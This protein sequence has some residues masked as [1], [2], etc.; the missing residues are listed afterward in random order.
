MHEPSQRL[1][2]HT[3]PHTAPSHRLSHLIAS[4]LHLVGPTWLG[5]FWAQ[6]A[7]RLT[8]LPG[9]GK[10]LFE[11]HVYS[12]VRA[13]DLIELEAVVM[14][15]LALL[16]HFE[17]STGLST[18]LGEWALDNIA[19]PLQPEAVARWWYGQASRRSSGGQSLGLSVWNYDGPGGWG[20]LVPNHEQPRSWWAKLNGGD[21]DG[22][23]WKWSDHGAVSAR[24][25]SGVGEL[26]L[27]S[28]SGA[29]ESLTVLFDKVEVMSWSR[30]RLLN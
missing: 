2:P 18:F 10:L 22:R 27:G 23:T 1:G 26:I 11:T 14:P 6:H 12:G 7:H 15:Q 17:R 25:V 29:L 21:D 4:R 20:A 30:E 16:R 3:S 5:S 9:A 24:H 8:S 28:P 19:P 13:T